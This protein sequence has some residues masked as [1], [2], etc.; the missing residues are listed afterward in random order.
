MNTTR[1][2]T[3]RANPIRGDH[4]MVCLPGEVDHGV[5]HFLDHLRVEREVGSSTAITFG[6]MVSARAIATR[7]CWPP[8]VWNIVWPDADLDPLQEFH[9]GRLGILPRKLRPDRRQRVVRAPVR[10]GNRSKTLEHHAD[11]AVDFIDLRQVGRSSK[12]STMIWLFRNSSSASMQRISVDLP[13]P[14]GPQITM[15]SPLAT[16]RSMSRST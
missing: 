5:E 6:F 10:R 3:S 2:A 7:C 13:E 12:P 4:H 9:R 8:D 1:S 16:S 14:E 15:R 11:L